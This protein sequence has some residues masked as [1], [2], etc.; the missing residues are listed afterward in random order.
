MNLKQMEYVLA[1]EKYGSISSAAKALY[2]ETTTVSRA[3]SELERELGAELFER[4]PQGTRLTRYGLTAVD[5]FRSV[6]EQ[7]SKLRVD[8]H[9]M[10]AEE[11]RYVPIDIGYGIMKS[12]TTRMWNTYLHEQVGQ[13]VLSPKD[14]PDHMVEEEVRNGT[15]ELGFTVGPVDTEEFDAHLLKREPLYLIVAKGH[16]LYEK[17]DLTL[18]DTR[19]CWFFSVN[20]WFR[21]HDL[22]QGWCRDCGFTPIVQYRSSD[23]ASLIEMSCENRG[24]LVVPA[25]WCTEKRENVR[26]V[27]LPF[28]EMSWDIYAIK[29]K[30]AG[31]SI[32]MNE[33]Y[34]H[35]V[36]YCEKE[37]RESLLI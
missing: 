13:R 19:D 7:L 29:R 17:E 33:F 24:L 16:R 15:V 31:L 5:C 23:I 34:R 14:L 26:F 27:P 9:D 10:K 4:T 18:A 2:V 21:L 3:I 12:L 36:E 35:C 28:P 32:K 20:E 8:I 25:C 30:N 22:F 37:F 11:Q 6:D 1:V